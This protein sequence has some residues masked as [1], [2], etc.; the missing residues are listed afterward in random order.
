ML[1]MFNLMGTSGL[2]PP[3]SRRRRTRGQSMASG[4]SYNKDKPNFALGSGVSSEDIHGP[5]EGKRASKVNVSRRGTA[6]SGGGLSRSN[7]S[8]R[9][10]SSRK[11]L[12]GSTHRLSVAAAAAA[13]PE[14]VGTPVTPEVVPPV[15]QLPPSVPPPSRPKSA[16]PSVHSPVV[17]TGP[18]LADLA[19]TAPLVEAQTAA[20]Q[21]DDGE[22]LIRA[23]ARHA[24]KGSPEDPNELSFAKGE[25]LEIED[26]EGK[27]WQAK[28]ADGTLGIVPSNYLVLL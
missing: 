13:E 11:S 24:Y 10:I 18:T 27:W 8:G 26:Q 19:S 21:D 17:A 9:S 5:Q 25:I 6:T 2:S 16:G 1:Y 4:F 12:V 7:T 23:R 3:S 20:P 28:K 22:V 15:P 14:Q